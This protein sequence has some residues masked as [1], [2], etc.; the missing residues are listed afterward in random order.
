MFFRLRSGI[1]SAEAFAATEAKFIR[2]GDAVE[3]DQAG[4][5]DVGGRA[6]AQPGES[7]PFAVGEG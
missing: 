1:R 7:G 4:V 3:K 2:L 6:D 5:L